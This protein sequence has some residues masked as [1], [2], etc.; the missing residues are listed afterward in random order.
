MQ[1]TNLLSVLVFLCSFTG[2]CPLLLCFYMVWRD[3]T[4]QFIEFSCFLVFGLSP[5]RA[6]KYLADLDGQSP[7]YCVIDFI[8]SLAALTALYWDDVKRCRLNV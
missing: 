3:A 6:R 8:E 7:F 1:R 5:S 2:F 4:N